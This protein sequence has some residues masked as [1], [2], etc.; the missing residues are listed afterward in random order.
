M[1]KILAK[2]GACL[3]SK[4]K[5]ALNTRCGLQ[6]YQPFPLGNSSFLPL[7]SGN[8]EK[9]LSKNPVSSQQVFAL[10]NQSAHS[11]FSQGRGNGEMTCSCHWGIS[12]LALG[13]VLETV[14]VYRSSKV[15]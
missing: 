9:G 3:G 2:G 14:S 15:V 5:E 11:S 12:P 4:E 1:R 7:Q 6:D 13:V 8:S 10:E